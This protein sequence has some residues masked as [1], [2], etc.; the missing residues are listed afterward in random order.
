MSGCTGRS[1]RAYSSGIRCV[2]FLFS[3]FSRSLSNPFL[4]LS[5][6]PTS[7]PARL[8]LFRVATSPVTYLQLCTRN[9][10]RF[11]GV[12]FRES[13]GEERSSFEEAKESSGTSCCRFLPPSHD[14]ASKRVEDRL[15][16]RRPEEGKD[17]LLSSAALVATKLTVALRDELRSDASATATFG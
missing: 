11:D 14:Q 2:P 1:Y 17:C 12:S 15:E 4:S 10:D 3:P 13:N 8:A 7:L 5:S 9:T 16:K 6:V